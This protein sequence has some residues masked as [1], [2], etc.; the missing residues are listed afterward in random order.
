MEI[1]GKI[2]LVVILFALCLSVNKHNIIYGNQIIETE[3]Q[4]KTID[5]LKVE[6]N[7]LDSTLVSWDIEYQQNLEESNNLV[8]E[9]NK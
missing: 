9:L 6:I 2:L 7:R 4:N 8:K 5:S 1:I 3:K